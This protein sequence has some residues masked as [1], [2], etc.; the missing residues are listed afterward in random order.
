MDYNDSI[1]PHVEDNHMAAFNLNVSKQPDMIA[2]WVIVDPEP[3]N[4]QRVSAFVSNKPEIT[5]NHQ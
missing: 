2:Y 5:G 4:H 3:E 1:P